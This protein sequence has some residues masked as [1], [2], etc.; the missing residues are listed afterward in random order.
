MMAR[1]PR[2]ARRGIALG[3]LALVVAAAWVLVAQPL[4]D[5]SASLFVEIG[6]LSE[7]VAM[8]RAI[9]AR[10]P[11]L[12]RRAA[13]DRGALDATGGLWRPTSAAELAAGMQERLRPAIAGT[14]GRLRSTAVVAEAEEHGMRRVTVHFSIQGSLQT[15]QAALAATE[16]ARP[17]MFVL[18]T[19]IH[20]AG[21][22]AMMD[23]AGPP[24]LTMEMDVSG[25]MPGPAT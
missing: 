18:A 19:T 6:T 15:I 17:A 20:A 11:A 4:I 3:V 25:F 2:P 14:G 5:L 10:T 12:Q 21:T 1:L 9:I 22:N 8:Q 23:P 16:A 24:P 13:A 7:R